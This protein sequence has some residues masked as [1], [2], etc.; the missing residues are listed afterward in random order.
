MGVG[1]TVSIQFLFYALCV[2]F[3]AYW[4]MRLVFLG[5]DAASSLAL[6]LLL[7]T[8]WVVI[9]FMEGRKMK[10]QYLPATAYSIFL[11]ALTLAGVEE[12][13]FLR[14]EG[15]SL[16]DA[17]IKNL[18]GILY[19]GL[20]AVTG[21]LSY[22]AALRATRAIRL[23]ARIICAV[24]F[25]YLGIL[26]IQALNYTITIH[27]ILISLVLLIIAFIN[28]LSIILEY[29]RTYNSFYEIRKLATVESHK[30]RIVIFQFSLYEIP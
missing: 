16:M 17:V 8:P 29:R 28:I 19:L 20:L 26:Y 24:F 12:G 6:G 10:F 23:A 9:L 5:V 15:L 21:Y 25:L 4:P 22:R 7:V 30:P 13:F 14:S 1:R 18:D 11:S 2:V 3:T 27:T